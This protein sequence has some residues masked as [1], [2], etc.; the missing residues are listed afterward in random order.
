MRRQ[1]GK[2]VIGLASQQVRRIRRR[3]NSDPNGHTVESTVRN[4]GTQAFSSWIAFTFTTNA[5][6]P[7]GGTGVIEPALKIPDFTVRAAPRPT[8]AHSKPTRFSSCGLS[9]S[10]R[11]RKIV[12][13]HRRVVV[14]RGG[15]SCK[16][17]RRPGGDFAPKSAM[18]RMGSSGRFAGKMGD[19]SWRSAPEVVCVPFR[20]V[21]SITGPDPCELPFPPKIAVP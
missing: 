9:E 2:T 1:R 20:K 13:E 15:V 6:I 3:R 17:G 18:T 19:Q 11:A 7:L 16:R 10:R 21:W 14:A 5:S 8:P 4:A 12:L